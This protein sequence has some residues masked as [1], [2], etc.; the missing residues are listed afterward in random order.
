[1]SYSCDICSA[2]LL[3]KDHGKF[4]D[5]QRVLTSPNYWEKLIGISSSSFNDAAFGLTLQSFCNDSSGFT[6]CQNCES[7]LEKDIEKSIEYGIERFISSDPT[8]AVD[9]T[10]VVVVAST[11]W[12]KIRGHWPTSVDKGFKKL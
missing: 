11:V 9:K 12:E 10:S 1:M 7:M 8:G 5:Q 2:S 6:I 4:I 3:S